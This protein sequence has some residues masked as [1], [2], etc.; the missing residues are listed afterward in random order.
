MI[1]SHLYQ[2]VQVPE[3]SCASCSQAE[4]NTLQAHLLFPLTVYP[5]QQGCTDTGAGEHSEQQNLCVTG[6]LCSTCVTAPHFVLFLRV[7]FPAF[8]SPVKFGQASFLCLLGLP[9]PGGREGNVL[10]HIQSMVSF[11]LFALSERLPLQHLPSAT[12]LVL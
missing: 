1:N 8:L 3:E 12:R 5:A 10:Q 7:C 9:C 4:H 6:C 2:M 11:L